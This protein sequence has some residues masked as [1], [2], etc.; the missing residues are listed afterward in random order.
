MSIASTVERYLHSSPAHFDLIDHPHTATSLQA[1]GISHI[2]REKMAKGVMLEDD[3]DHY[4][5]AVL[6]ATQKVE[7][8]RLK[9]QMN[10]DFHLANERKFRKTFNDCEHGAVPP[11]GAAYGVETIWDEGLLGAGDLYFE[12][13]DHKTLVHMKT[14]DFIRLLGD[15]QPL[16][17]AAPEDFGGAERLWMD[18]DDSN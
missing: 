14:S 7:L 10:R 6:P 12:A 17:F 9:A 11:L 4:V 5:L 18:T 8:D 16:D 1:A 13:G 3:S 15:A 2:P